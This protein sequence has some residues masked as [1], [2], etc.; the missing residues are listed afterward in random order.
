MCDKQNVIP[1]YAAVDET[2]ELLIADMLSF[3]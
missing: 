1:E 3:K 2:K